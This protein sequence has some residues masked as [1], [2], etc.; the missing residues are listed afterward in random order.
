MTTRTESTAQP[1][2]ALLEDLRSLVT[3]AEK[4]I[5]GT[6]GE[7]AADALGALRTRFDAAQARLGELYADTRQKVVA[8]AKCTDQAIRANP[9][10]ALALALGAGLLVGVLLG[11]RSR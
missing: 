3:E 7:H 10:Q 2:Q 4:L 6:P 11:R 9:Y 8:G 5:D 1:P